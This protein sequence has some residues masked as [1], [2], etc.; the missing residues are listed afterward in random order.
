MESNS[1]KQKRNIVIIEKYHFWRI[2]LCKIFEQ[3]L[4]ILFLQVS[5]KCG[6]CH[7]LLV[8]WFRQGWDLLRIKVRVLWNVSSN[9][10]HEFS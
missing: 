6:P 3:R 5:T 2:K 9:R 8:S 7:A 4:Q 1:D 10:N